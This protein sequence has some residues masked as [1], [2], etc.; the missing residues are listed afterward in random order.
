MRNKF[1]LILSIIFFFSQAHSTEN[2]NI[3]SENISVDKKKE[4][5]IFENKVYIQDKDFNSIKSE[6]AEYNRK[7]QILKI[8]KNIL[9]KDKYGNTIKGNEINYNIN[10]KIIKSLGDI[11]ITTVDGY[12]INSKNIILDNKKNI[13]KSDSQTLIKDLDENTIFLENFELLLD[14][15]IIKSVGLIKLVDFKKNTYKFSQIYIDSKKKEIIGTDIKAFLN[16]KDFLSHENNKPRIFANSIQF[17]NT[18]TNFKNSTFTMCDYR[19]NDKCPPWEL[20]A[21]EMTHDNQK[22]TIFYKNALLKIY[23][24]PIFYIPVLS[25]PDPT[26]DRRSG[27]LPPAFSNSKNLGNAIAVPYY[28]NIN[29]DKDF[30]LTNRLYDSEHP[31]FLGEYRQAFKNSSLILDNGYTAGYKKTTSKKNG[32]SK[33]H[34]F[35]SFTKNFRGKKES[36]NLFEI[37]LQNVSHDDYLKLY[38]IDSALVDHE[39]N[40]LENSISFSHH[41]NDLFFG[42]ETNI[43]R[44]LNNSNNERYEYVFPNITFDKN[45]FSSVQYGSMDVQ[46]NFKVRNFETNK[47]EKFLINDFSWKI[48]ENNFESGLRGKWL[49]NFKN[50]NYETKNITK[51]KNQ[52]TSE[53]YGALGYLAELNL[54]K[55]KDRYNHYLT[56]KF[57]ARFS[58]NHMKQAE[59]GSKLN[60]LNIFTLNR[61]DDEKNFEGGLNTTIGFDYSLKNKDEVEKLKFSLAQI[62]NEK[63]NKNMPSKSSLNEKLS[64]S[65]GNVKI[66]VSENINFNYNFL[67]DQNYNDL[68]YSDLSV[69]YNNDLIKFNINYISENKHIGDKSYIKSKLSYLPNEKTSF[70]IDNKR[71]LIKNSSEYYDLSYEYFND[72]LRAGLVYRR[73]FYDDPDLEAEN[74]LMFKV[75]LIPFGNLDGPS[76]NN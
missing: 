52:T 22:K 47:T 33:G 41:N 46:S 38:K 8:K 28:F 70:S 17:K 53:V 15:N 1:L 14:K 44:D 55:K 75:T 7:K 25:H 65:V 19:E 74:S 13:L 26:V 43:F 68:N 72:C 3:E 37:N 71:N 6:Y 20:R 35:S 49:S 40:I 24:I 31:L 9:I 23:D 54:Y 34:F 42:L 59:D 63:E 2:L 69:N 48:K 18:K 50:V 60:A 66:N 5:T 11:H 58:P 4:T 10:S 56:P 16:D 29:K 62:I 67:L 27:F 30:T 61:L 51:F 57:L 76:L 39:K 45:L 21:K 73:E 36:V 64:D 12:S 32:G